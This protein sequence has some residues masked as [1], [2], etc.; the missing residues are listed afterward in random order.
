MA[1]ILPT[2]GQIVMAPNLAILSM[3]TTARHITNTELVD[4]REVIR[5]VRDAKF[6]DGE[7]RPYKPGTVLASVQPGIPFST[8]RAVRHRRA[9]PWA[10]FA[11]EILKR[12]DGNY[13]L[14]VSALD[15]DDPMPPRQ[16]GWNCAICDEPVSAVAEVEGRELCLDCWIKATT[17]EERRRLAVHLSCPVTHARLATTVTAGASVEDL[18]A[19]CA[20]TRSLRSGP[21][22]PECDDEHMKMKAWLKA[23]GRI[24]LADGNQ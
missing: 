19:W 21:C 11:Q 13:D 15:P 6:L 5:G 22:W 14:L 10:W 9:A 24:R 1:L 16:R 2:V 12:E 20:A 8:I 7:G 3:D 23:S 4:L 18:N 17:A